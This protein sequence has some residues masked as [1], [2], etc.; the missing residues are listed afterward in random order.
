MDR[1][2]GRIERISISPTD[3]PLADAAERRRDLA[4]QN[5]FRIRVIKQEF[6]KAEMG[7]DLVVMVLD[8]DDPHARRIYEDSKGSPRGKRIGQ[9]ER[10]GDTIQLLGVD[11]SAARELFSPN[12]RNLFDRCRPSDIRVAVL[13]GGR[14]MAMLMPGDARLDDVPPI[15]MVQTEEDR[16]AGTMVPPEYLPP[17]P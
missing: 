6:V 14:T 8:L 7:D 17:M 10:P 12:H 9:P 15:I 1:W 11:Y 4:S 13:S 3:A 2:N 5:E 16:K